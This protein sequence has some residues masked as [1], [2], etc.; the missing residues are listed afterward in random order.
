MRKCKEITVADFV[1]DL[2]SLRRDL[3][4]GFKALHCL[5]NQLR[6]EIMTSKQDVLDAI[7]SE[8]AD[9]IKEIQD[10]KDQIASG[11]PVTSA[12]LDEIIASVKGMSGSDQTA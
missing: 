11:S 3:N 4:K 9:I 8:K 10:L 1:R 5:I 2:R 7:A 12:D 6:E